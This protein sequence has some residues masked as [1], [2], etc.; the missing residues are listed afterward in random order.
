[1]A[2][3]SA[4]DALP[5]NV[6]TPE[7]TA[8]VFRTVCNDGDTHVDDAMWGAAGDAIRA[9]FPLAQT[10]GEDGLTLLHFAA[11]TFFTRAHLPTVALAL[12][13]G[14]D[15]NAASSAEGRRAT[16][17]MATPV[18]MAAAFG[19]VEVLRELLQA[20]G[21][22][23]QGD[24]PLVGLARHAT[25]CA[26][27]GDSAADRLA[28]LLEQPTLDLDVAYNG[29]GVVQLARSGGWPG[30]ADMIV[31]EVGHRLTVAELPPPPIV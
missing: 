31:E 20:G 17:S 2:M 28:L 25:R 15:P 12:A 27:R 13:H 9:G 22:V 21:D 19:T 11:G 3:A 14:A 24:S 16:N 1:M 23:A 10:D 7:A 26:D 8:R 6:W 29:A 4:Q 18:Y 5:A 30:L